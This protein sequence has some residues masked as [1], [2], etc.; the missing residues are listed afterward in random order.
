MFNKKFKLLVMAVGLVAVLVVGL[1]VPGVTQ[2]SSDN[3]FARSNIVKMLQNSF[4]QLVAEE[5]DTVLNIPKAI[6]WSDPARFMAF[7]PPLAASVPLEKIKAILAGE[8]NIV[9]TIGGLY[10]EEDLTG[11]FPKGVYK[12]KLVGK[13]KVIF[14]DREGNEIYEGRVVD[15]RELDQPSPEPALMFTVMCQGHP[16]YNG[17]GGG[18]GGEGPSGGGGGVNWCFY[19]KINLIVAEF[20]VDV[21]N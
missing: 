7:V 19:I 20:G 15:F 1:V 2:D 5:G 8:E 13:S 9:V 21:H 11:R 18:G 17:G 3:P 10:V 16:C 14:V 4:A 12:I 6:L